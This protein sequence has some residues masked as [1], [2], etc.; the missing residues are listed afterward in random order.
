MRYNIDTVSYYTY[1]HIIDTKR[2]RTTNE[3]KIGY[4]YERDISGMHRHFTSYNRTYIKLRVSCVHLGAPFQQQQRLQEKKIIS[5]HIYKSNGLE[6]NSFQF[7]CCLLSSFQYN[8]A[9]Q[10][11]GNIYINQNSM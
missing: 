6:M 5:V 9:V 10:V 3:H 4:T 2:K 8:V 7:R 11:K 1:L